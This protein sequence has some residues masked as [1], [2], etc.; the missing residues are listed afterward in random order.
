MGQSV[1][2][3]VMMRAC[4]NFFPGL[5]SG[6]SLSFG[7]GSLGIG[8]ELFFFFLFVP[9]SSEIYIYTQGETDSSDKYKC[10]MGFYSPKSP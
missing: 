7:A 8:S 1:P 9:L 6:F 10:V 5:G 2:E 3:R 4:F